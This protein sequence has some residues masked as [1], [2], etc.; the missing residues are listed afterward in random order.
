MARITGVASF[1]L[2]SIGLAPIVAAQAQAPVQQVAPGAPAAA[3]APRGAGIPGFN[4]VVATVTVDGRTEKITK[5]EVITFMSHYPMPAEEEREGSY[6]TT[7]D[8][9]VNTRLLMMYL[10]RQRIVV[11]QEKVDEQ[12]EQ[13]KQELKKDGQDLGSALLQNGIA[14]D[15]VRK[16]YENRIRWS[17]F[18]KN[19]ASDATLRKF[20]A[21]HH[22]LFSGTALRASHILIKLDPTASEAEKEK[23]RQKLAKIKKE[24][25]GGTLTFAVAANKYSEDPA[26]SGGAGGDL[27]YFSLTSGLVEEFTDVAFRLKKGVISDPV[28]T[29]FGMH[30]ITVT[31]RK[32]GKPVDFE[33]N[34]PYILNAYGSELQKSI[35]TAE[36]KKATVD[37]K[38]MPK[39]L[40]PSQPAT[41]PGGGSEKS[42]SAAPAGAAAPK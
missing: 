16:E 39:D 42:K 17:E 37:V 2:V 38:P 6:R 5:G 13:L 33:Q 35:V 10:A 29:P 20:V 22:D 19:K 31:D 25:E 27:D 40:F 26:N 28:E 12:I 24:I 7:V 18:V 4:D 1:V 11:T 21:D 3:P 15:D 41:A 36:R 32:E 8:S 23:A 9:L 14:I 30:L 34:K